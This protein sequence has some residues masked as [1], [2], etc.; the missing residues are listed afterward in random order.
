[1]NPIRFDPAAFTTAPGITLIEA[2]AG[3]GKTFSITRIVVEQ[4]AS[5]EARIEEV[6]VLTFTDKATAELKDRIRSAIAEGVEAE[7]EA[8]ESRRSSLLQSAL[9]SFDSASIYTI[10]GFCN[11]ILRQYGVEAGLGPEFA[12]LKDTRRFDQNLE[13]AV[14]REFQN[15][16]ARHRWLP[17]GIKALDLPS[18]F[19]HNTLRLRESGD[20]HSHTPASAALNGWFERR[21][22]L[23]QSLWKQERIQILAELAG[24]QTPVK[25]QTSAYREA[26]L[27]HTLGELDQVFN[28]Q[29]EPGQHFIHG[30]LPLARERLT[31]A[32]RKGCSLSSLDFYACV[33][34][35]ASD[36]STLCRLLTLRTIEMRQ[37]RLQSLVQQ[38]QSLRFDELLTLARDL[39]CTPDAPFAE[40][41]YAQFKLGLIDEFQDTDP[42]QFEILEHLFLKPPPGEPQRPLILIGDPKQAIYG[43][44]GGDIFT[45]GK[46]KQLAG[47]HYYL[48][49]NWRSC[50]AINEGVNELLAQ[51]TAPFGFSWIEY[52]QVHTALKNA[53]NSLVFPA[54]HP[55]PFPGA[56][57]SW[58]LIANESGESRR[59]RQVA[60]DIAALLR[61]G[62]QLRTSK[63][64]RPLGPSDIAVLVRNNRNGARVHEALGQRRI[65]ATILGGASVFASSEAQQLYTVL[66]A[67]LT[68]RN[69]RLLRA[70]ATGI[71]FDPA[72][73]P[74]L[75][76][77]DDPRWADIAG[78]FA[79]ASGQW[80]NRGLTFAL[81]H[82]EHVFDWKDHLSRSRDPHR[83]LAN[84]HQIRQLLLQREATERLDPDALL[85]WFAEQIE[86][87][88]ATDQDQM[89]QL[90]TDADAVQILT[91]HK[92]KGLEFPVVFLPVLTSTRKQKPARPYQYHDL[93]SGELRTCFENYD[94][95]TAAGSTKEMEVASENL[96]TLYVAITRA[97]ISCHIYAVDD[98]AHQELL[99]PWLPPAP[100]LEASLVLLQHAITEPDATPIVPAR[101][102][103]SGSAPQPVL[104]SPQPPP[105]IPHAPVHLSFTGIVR[106]ATPTLAPDHDERLLAS[107]AG[108]R[109][110]A[111]SADAADSIFTFERGTNAGLMFHDL[112]E[113]IDLEHPET[114]GQQICHSLT[115]YGYDPL[116]WEGV[117]LPWLDVLMQADLHLPDGCLH[118]LQALDP[119]R[120]FR[121][122]DF[123]FP[124][125][126]G[127]RTWE[128]L[129]A[130]FQQSDWVQEL[131][132]QLP[133]PAIAREVLEAWIHGVVDAW[134][135]NQDKHYL[136]DWK[137]NHLGSS[138]GDYHAQALCAAMAEHH[139]HLQYLLYLCALNRYLRLIRPDYNY[140]RDFGGVGY[141]FFRGIGSGQS[142][143]GWFT[144]LPPPDF[145]A[146]LETIL[147][148]NP[149]TQEGVNHA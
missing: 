74:L 77:E 105:A 99:A 35:V 39:V 93:Q 71:C 79:T 81:T 115:A 104:V 42:T 54:A 18:K 22:Q 11:R 132:Y 51:R 2:S 55:V 47:Q 137:S 130:L 76:Q 87:P 101:A 121:E 86:D 28:G 53:A 129:D 32:L 113:S 8:G 36:L 138:P 141:C 83:A 100:S 136:L 33:D 3:T 88:D 19:I 66:A 64:T 7:A 41:L 23:L 149:A 25:R 6:L 95:L 114:W 119:H 134:Y 126:W 133:T 92:S 145:V 9:E 44:R 135:V 124:I 98:E 103:P 131:G 112:L 17:A 106:G 4:I 110:D 107:L 78:S 29:V 111:P 75:Q 148:P 60:D 67:M 109:S 140:A 48:D 14:A 34:G 65:S 12:V 45:Y 89:L 82:L 72:L 61:S 5:G 90:E 26:N 97:G 108:N 13:I 43:F 144:T 20:L 15:L 142:N 123:S 85:R 1:M 139:Y 125:T 147:Y 91:M 27:N 80:Q 94:T 68:P 96:R 117:L 16:A 37:E 24:P 62:A 10:H 30:L 59:I 52:Q 31:H 49:T 102:V 146:R 128:Q 46:A 73:L 69:Q 38:E 56:G 70:A 116:R 58:K 57:I 118:Q 84:H 143:A 63:E 40:R 21:F 127:S 50:P 120:F 122:T